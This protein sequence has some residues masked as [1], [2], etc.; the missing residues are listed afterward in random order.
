MPVYCETA[1]SPLGA[2]PAEPVNTITS[3][4][5]AILGVLA[6]VFLIRHGSRNPVAY[7]LA[8]LTLLTGL[9]S[10]AWHSMRTPTTLLVDWLP[11]AIYFL[12]LVFVW[13]YYA[14]GRY[15]S[16]G[17][18]LALSGLVFFVPFPVIIRY[19]L[20]II[21]VL[22]AIASGLVFATWLRRRAAFGWALAMVVAA[23][24]A[25][26]A[27]TL[28]LNVCDV[29]PVGTHF[30]WHIFLGGAA[31]AGV[32]LIVRLHTAPDVVRGA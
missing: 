7:V 2:F 13:S 14:A 15:L 23:I 31:Y 19:R 3:F 16:V 24:V 11:G 10:V 17:L 8:V 5:P 18:I 9:G 1:L 20:I 26:T 4:V 30:L 29:I 32:R 27:R 28:D 21:A 22:V 25:V 12:I 6:L